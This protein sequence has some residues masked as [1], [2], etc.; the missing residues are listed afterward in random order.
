[1]RIVVQEDDDPGFI[2]E[3]RACVSGI[4]RSY[5]P[6]ELFLIKTDNWF[7]DN[8]FRFKG[9]VLGLVGRWSTERAL[10]ITIPPFVP[11]RILWERR[12]AAPDYKQIAI[13]SII[14]AKVPSARAIVRF[15]DGVAPNA[16]ICWYSGG[17][18]K[19]KRGAIMAYLL[20]EG[21]YWPWYLGWELSNTWK[22]VKLVGASAE[23]IAEIRSRKG[24][25]VPSQSAN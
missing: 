25:A 9:K 2:E 12:Y 1:M 13:R 18:H 11:H 4:V 23:E 15:M 16:S 19:N 17:S 8:W 7:G 6:A 24:P 20:V 5:R 14:H 22:M 10:R 21:S 3:V